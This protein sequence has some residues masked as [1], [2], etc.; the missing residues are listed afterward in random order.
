MMLLMT[1]VLFMVCS[2]MQRICVMSAYV[3][4]DMAWCGTTNRVCDVCERARMCYL[5]QGL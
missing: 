1:L 4:C 5:W 3:I 2:V